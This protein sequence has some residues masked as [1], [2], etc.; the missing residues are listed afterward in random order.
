MSVTKLKR[1]LARYGIGNPLNQLFYT[2]KEIQKIRD[3]QMEENVKPYALDGK[4]I[5]LACQWNRHEISGDDF[6]NAFW[7]RYE[8]QC[9]RAW[10]KMISE[11][12]V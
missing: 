2:T 12:K 4:L 6:A 9:L 3:S 10:R 1:I 5:T 11:E 8:K 7:E